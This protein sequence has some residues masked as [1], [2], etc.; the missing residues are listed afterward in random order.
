MPALVLALVPAVVW[1]LSHRLL[2]TMLNRSSTNNSNS[3]NSRNERNNSNS[4]H[5]ND[6]S[7]SS[8]RL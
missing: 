8:I 1:S 3:N 6:S 7:N 4:S 2:S 5:D